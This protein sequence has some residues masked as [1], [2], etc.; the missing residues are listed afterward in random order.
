MNKTMIV[1]A[2]LGFQAVDMPRSAQA[3]QRVDISL[4]SSALDRNELG[5]M[6]NRQRELAAYGNKNV[7]SMRGKRLQRVET[8]ERTPHAAHRDRV[9]GQWGQ[10]SRRYCRC[11][12]IIPNLCIERKFW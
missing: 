8:C 11:H 2:S 12:P 7:L 6:A 1:V 3:F 4:Q 5:Y 9:R 10:T